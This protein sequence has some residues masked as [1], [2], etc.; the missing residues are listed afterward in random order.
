MAEFLRQPARSSFPH[1]S[2]SCGRVAP[3]PTSTDLTL[4]RIINRTIGEA[5]NA[6]C[7]HGGQTLKA[8]IAVRQVRPDIPAHEALTL[9][10]RVRE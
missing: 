9:V 2:A 5:R 10:H 1:L 8:V 6:G 3:S 4:V 7:D